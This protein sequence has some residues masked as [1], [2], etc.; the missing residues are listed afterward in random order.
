MASSKT[1]T[2]ALV[3]DGT[4]GKSSITQVFVKDGFSPVYRQTLGVDFLEKKCSLRGDMAVSVRLRDIGG[5]SISSSNLDKYISGAD[6]VFLVYDTT[7]ADSFNNLD[8]WL[9][10]VR[11]HCPPK[12]RLYLLG[13]KIDLMSSRQVSEDAHKKFAIDESL[14]GHM[15]VSAKSGEQLMR[16]FYR[17]MMEICDLPVTEAD[18]AAHDKVLSAAVTLSGDDEART[19]FA[20]E[21]EEEERRA[22]ERSQAGCAGAC[23]IC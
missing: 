5:Q 17:A 19:A 22:H 14:G 10:M 23:V 2:L 7:N 8:D 20:D 12:S 1:I 21:I 9:T 15:L 3:G 18:L 16:G 6:G 4:V 11:K 13:N